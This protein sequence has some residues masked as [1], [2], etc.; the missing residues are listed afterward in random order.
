MAG[1]RRNGVPERCRN[2][3][4]SGGAA[5]RTVQPRAAA[6]RDALLAAAR[7]LLRDRD[8]EAVSIAGLAGANGLSVGS[9]YGRF[10]DKESFFALLQ[11][12]VS[13]EW[14]ERG[15]ALLAAA[16]ADARPAARLVADLCAVYI[17]L[18]R[19]DAGFVRA[20]LK[21]ASTHPSSW[22][23]I[24]STGEAYVNE[25]VPVLAPRL[26]R[27]LPAEREP[28]IRFAMQLL[29]GT[30]LNAVLNDPGPIRLA[31]PRL[32]HSLAQVMAAYLAIDP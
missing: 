9:F 8:W 20:S 4:P 1:L 25:I 26:E 17:G 5:L 2:A 23:P 28:R 21:H 15:R 6:T 32:E 18:M 19:H 11:Q 29:Y 7:N 3:T 13:A 14:L 16:R 27:L 10:R 24:K 30:G 12:Q 31:D 22:T